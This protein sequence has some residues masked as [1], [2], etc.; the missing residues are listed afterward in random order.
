MDGPYGQPAFLPQGGNR[1]DQSLPRTGYGVDPQPLSAHGHFPE[2]VLGQPPSP[3]QRT[4]P[5]DEDVFCNFGRTHR[6]FD[7]LPGPLHPTPAQGGMAFGAKFRS[8]GHLRGGIH[9]QPDKTLLTLPAGILF[10]RRRLLALGGRFMP[11]H[12]GPSPP[13]DSRAS[14]LS[15]RW[16]SSEMTPCCS[17]MIASRVSRL[18]RSSPV[19]IVPRCHNSAPAASMFQ[20]GGGLRQI[21]LTKSEQLRGGLET[22]QY[23]VYNSVLWTLSASALA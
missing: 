16:R 5:G 11:R 9:P 8:V 3:A 4:P 19:S 1:A 12:P 6:K 14:R 7:D 15:T 21:P 23:L 10:F 18:A 22:V 20:R 17:A 13:P 2:V